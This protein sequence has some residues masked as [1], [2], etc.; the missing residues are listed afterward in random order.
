MKRIIC[1]LK[2]LWKIFDVMNI[3]LSTG[4]LYINH[5]Y[6]EIETENKNEQVLVC[7]V[8]GNRS[9]AY[10]HLKGELT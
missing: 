8:C 6:R 7:D 9:V 1:Y 2:T 10:Y 4:G 5:E 3:Y